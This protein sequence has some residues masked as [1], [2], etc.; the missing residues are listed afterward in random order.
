MRIEDRLRGLSFVLLVAFVWIFE[1]NA[2]QP[3]PARD[4][5]AVCAS[6]HEGIYRSYFAALVYNPNGKDLLRVR[7]EL[8]NCSATDSK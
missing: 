1:A 3:R 4:A 5:D 7:A 2:L 6:C 8:E